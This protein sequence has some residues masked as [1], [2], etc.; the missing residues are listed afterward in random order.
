MRKS[1]IAQKGKRRQAVSSIWLNGEGLVRQTD[2]KEVF[3]CYPCELEK[4]SQQLPSLAG[5]TNAQV[6]LQNVHR[7]DKDGKP[8]PPK[9]PQKNTPLVV[10]MVVK[11][12]QFETFKDLLIRWIV[13][14]QLALNMLENSYFRELVLWLN[15][16]I[17]QLLPKA[18]ATLRQWIIDAWLKEKE[19]LKKSLAIA[20]SN[21]HLSFDLWTSPNHYT[22]LAIYAHFIDGKGVRRQRLLAFKRLKG[23]HTG[24]NQAATILEVIKDYSID[25]RIGYFMADNAQSNDTAIELILKELY[26]RLTTEQRVARRLRCLGHITNLCAR[27]LLLGKGASKAMDEAEAQ[28]R[29]GDFDALDR[30][31]RARGAIGRLHNIVRYVRSTPQRMEEFAEIRK[32]GDLADFDDLEVSSVFLQ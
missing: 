15:K 25:D 27:A 30:F 28:L 2:S 18:R 22:I 13:Y 26:P 9:E 24:E 6:H 31:W 23:A 17:G 4:K 8:L 16:G 1:A 29:K 21:I 10:N 5:T 14:C 7:L 20:L 12:Y 19:Q 11:T 32:G 3:Y